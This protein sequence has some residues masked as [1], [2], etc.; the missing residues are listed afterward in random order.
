MQQTDTDLVGTPGQQRFGVDLKST[1]ACYRQALW[2][3][4]PA[5]LV[6]GAQAARRAAGGAD[7]E[8]R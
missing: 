4:L 3:A 5:Q 7:A 1:D 2:G 6:S 8:Q